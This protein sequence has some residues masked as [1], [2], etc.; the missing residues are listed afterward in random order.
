MVYITKKHTF[1]ARAVLPQITILT[2][3]E[4]ISI[5]FIV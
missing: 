2:E 3:N 1:I 5:K 4:L